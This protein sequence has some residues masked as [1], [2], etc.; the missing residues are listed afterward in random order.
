MDAFIL[1][2]ITKDGKPN[3]NEKYLTNIGP[4]DIKVY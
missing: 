4:I 3:R 2:Y 1:S